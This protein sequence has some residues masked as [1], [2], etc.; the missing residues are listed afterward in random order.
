MQVIVLQMQ[1]EYYATHQC[2]LTRK[3]LYVICWRVTDGIEGVMELK[4][5]LLSI[6]VDEYYICIY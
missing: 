1:E 3:A 6:Q 2:Y 4:E 5:W